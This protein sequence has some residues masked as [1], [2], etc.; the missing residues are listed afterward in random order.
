MGTS[1]NKRLESDE[2]SAQLGLGVK[3]ARKLRNLLWNRADEFEIRTFEGVVM[4]AL[5]LHA[6]RTFLSIRTLAR[7]GTVNDAMA[8]VRVMVE[9]VINAEYIYLAGTDTAIDYVEFDAFREWRDHEERREFDPKVDES[10]DA[11]SLDKTHSAYLKART[12]TLANGTTINRFGR[13]HDWIEMGLRKRAET[14]DDQIGK[15]FEANKFPFAQILYFT[16]FKKSSRYLHGL[17]ES[18]VRTLGTPQ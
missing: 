9:K 12:R 10:Y 6:E 11:D 8:L 13:G 5:F 4:Y 15:K 18:V 7:K 17:W 14:V 16:A 1:D 2:L 3:I